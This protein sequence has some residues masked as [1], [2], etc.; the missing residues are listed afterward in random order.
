MAYALSNSTLL[1]R[2]GLTARIQDLRDTLAKRA[3]RRAV[4]NRTMAELQVLNDRDLA[5]LGFHRSEIPH[6]AQQAADMA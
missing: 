4:Y 6:I 2:I 1:D 5:D 3:A